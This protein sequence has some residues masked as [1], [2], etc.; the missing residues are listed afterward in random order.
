MGVVT[1]TRVQHASPAGTYAH[2]VNREWY[3]DADMPAEALQE[4]CQD[5]ARQ[6]IS[7]V[8]IDVSQEGRGGP[9]QATV[10]GNP[11]LS[12]GAWGLGQ[13]ASR[14]QAHLP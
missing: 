5:I 7:N 1:T 3:S 9:T 2:V 13:R 10:P 8:D 11:S 14:P 4:G 6:L 12:P